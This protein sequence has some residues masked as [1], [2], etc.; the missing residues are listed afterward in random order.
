MD[1]MKRRRTLFPVSWLRLLAAGLGVGLA[2]CSCAA[3]AAD[4]DILAPGFDDSPLHEPVETPDWFKL[5]FLDLH[6]DVQ[7][8]TK[9][10]KRGL[11]VYFGQKYCPYCKALLE[12]DF[13]K[14]D[15][16]AYTRKYF[17]V[18]AINTRGSRLV[19]DMD[20]R[21]L[22]E[23][24]FAIRRKANFTPTLV[25]YGPDYKEVFRLVGYHG[26]YQFRAALE[27]VADR[28]YLKETF[29][30]YL[31]RAEGA[32]HFDEGELNHRDF[33]SRPPYALDR[34]RFPAQRPLVVFFERPNCHACD[35]L[36]AGPLEQ[37]QTLKL[38]KGFEVVQLNMRSNTPLVTPT[39]ERTTA[40][41]WA[42]RLGLFYAPTLIF[43]DEHGREI[44][45]IAS[46]VHFNRLTSVLRYVH[47]K[48]YEKYGSYPAWRQHT[49]VD[50]PPR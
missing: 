21:I 15:V 25:F 17:D 48:G 14:P 8:A 4:A 24:D 11:I 20:G 10:G 33:F 43:F 35:V 36:Y 5:S 44:I 32:D 49:H 26:P 30:H 50:G 6:D 7:E 39:G 37:A 46:V 19:T 9:D 31:A 23:D 47:E 38:L 18:V 12:N 27:Y 22:S 28:H 34:S 41:G 40:R 1:A 16:V 45:R 42:E 2:L 29:R 13:G 3:A